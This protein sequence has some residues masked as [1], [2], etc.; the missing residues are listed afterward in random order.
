ML[1]VSENC[2]ENTENEI[3]LN[4]EF[5]EYKL[6]CSKAHQCRVLVLK[7]HIPVLETE[8][9]EDADIASAVQSLKQLKQWLKITPATF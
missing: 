3:Y 8:A 4:K 5:Y 7:K 1:N 2:W 6:Y 9:A